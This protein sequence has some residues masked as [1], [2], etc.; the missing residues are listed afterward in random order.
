MILS[1]Q[2]SCQLDLEEDQQE[3]QINTTPYVARLVRTGYLGPNAS[4]MV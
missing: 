2:L 4:D 3:L 1:L